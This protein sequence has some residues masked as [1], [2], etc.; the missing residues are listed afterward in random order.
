MPTS[1]TLATV[2]KTFHLTEEHQAAI[3]YYY[4]AFNGLIS[5]AQLIKAA[6]NI[7]FAQLSEQ[8]QHIMPPKQD[9]A[10]DK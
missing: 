9:T 6:L 1:A 8:Y 10:N 3:L 7:G 5:Q 4:N 2:V